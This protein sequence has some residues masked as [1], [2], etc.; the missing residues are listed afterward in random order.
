MALLSQ[1]IADAVAADHLPR[2]ATADDGSTHVLYFDI[3]VRSMGAGEW[4][5]ALPTEPTPAEIAAAVQTLKAAA[6]AAQADSAALRQRV[7]QA[8]TSAVGVQVDQLTAGQVR[9]LI[10]LLLWKQGAI[11][12]AGAVLPLAG[13]L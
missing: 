6:A 1:T 3:V 7:I 8:A 11:D 5:G 9:A 4:Q 2:V 13:W 10:A 12:K